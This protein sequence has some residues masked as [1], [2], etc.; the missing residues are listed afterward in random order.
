[1][2]KTYLKTSF[3]LALICACAAFILAELNGVTAP[4]I[5][6]YEAQKTLSALEAVSN[7]QEIGDE[8]FVTDNEI[9][10]AYY[11]LTTEGKTSGYLLKMGKSGY[12]GMVNLVASYD[13]N[14]LV[15][16]AKVVSDSETPGLGKKSEEDWYMTKFIG[17]NPI[18]TKKSEL[19]ADDAAAISGA[20]ITFG[21][22]SAAL[23]AG[24]QFVK[25]KGAK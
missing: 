14:G 13:L 2:T 22:V 1:M 10:S 6:A 19:S 16:A 21:A 7:G 5:A 8:E 12:G 23:D 9:V 18:P 24:S 11:P 17:A 20:S 4:K 15:T 3:I 25:T